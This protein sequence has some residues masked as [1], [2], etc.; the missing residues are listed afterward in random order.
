MIIDLIYVIAGFGAGIAAGAWGA[1]RSLDKKKRRCSCGHGVGTH[2]DAK[3]CQADVVIK[4]Y[5]VRRV[6]GAEFKVHKRFRWNEVT[7]CKCQLFDGE[8]PTELYGRL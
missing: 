5:E 1:V 7:K 4:R 2:K 8:I 6:P 3:Q